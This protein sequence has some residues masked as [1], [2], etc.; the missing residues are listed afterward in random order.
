MVYYQIYNIEAELLL[1]FVGE[2]NMDPLPLSLLD[3][4]RREGKRDQYIQK[5]IIVFTSSEGLI[6]VGLVK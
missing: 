5:V 3:A 2:C 1:M 6:S 4:E